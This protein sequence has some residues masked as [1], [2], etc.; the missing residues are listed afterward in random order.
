[1]KRKKPVIYYRTQEKL[2]GKCL[3]PTLIKKNYRL[4]T[5][6]LNPLNLLKLAHHNKKKAVICF[7]KP[8]E[9]AVQSDFQTFLITRL[10]L[11]CQQA[12]FCS[13]PLEQPLV[14]KELTACNQSITSHFRTKS[15]FHFQFLPEQASLIRA[16]IDQLDT[17]AQ[18][19]DL[20]ESKDFLTYPVSHDQKH[21]TILKLGGLCSCD[22]QQSRNQYLNN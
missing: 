18:E 2:V 17:Y 1:M 5:R 19:Y 4:G 12:E 10:L 16:F 6:S 22:P 15:V 8:P 14:P 21:E 11:L 13:I 7:K 9:Q 3:K 20:E